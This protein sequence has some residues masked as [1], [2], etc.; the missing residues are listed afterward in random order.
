MFC[1]SI[2]PVFLEQIN[3]DGD[4]DIRT[5]NFVQNGLVAYLLLIIIIIII[6]DKVSLQQSRPAIQ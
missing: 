1:L 5:L 2:C 6:T 4:G 3:G